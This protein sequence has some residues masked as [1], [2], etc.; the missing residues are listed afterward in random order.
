[1]A[2]IRDVANYAKVSVGTVSN[3]LNNSPLVKDA[4]R[5]RVL[6]AIEA[7]DFHPMAAARTLTTQRTNTL[8]MVRTE[9]R[10][11]NSRIES[12][13]VILDL[14][15]GITSAAVESGI[16]LTFWT[17]YVGQSEMELYR[18][19]VSGR[20]VDGF[21]LFALREEDPRIQY[22]QEQNFP[23]VTFGRPEPLETSYWIDVDSAYGIETSVRH[24]F[25]LG[26]TRI[27]YIAPPHEQFLARQRWEGFT[28]GMRA[29]GLVINS[30]FIY[31]GD[32]SERSGQ[33]G[34]HYFLDLPEPPTAIICSNDRMALG[35][36]H[37]AQSRHLKV[38][39]DISI[40][41]YD[42]IPL[43]RYSYPSLTTL[44]QPTSQIGGMLF[45]LLTSI[46]EEQPDT[47]LT[48][49]LIKP[50]LHVRQSTGIHA[51][52]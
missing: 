17:T 10:P 43:S 31:E 34:T 7:L 15:E 12:D 27:A 52:K 46:I 26:H 28:S 4:T 25:D 35:A 19:L 49:H 22:L 39:K 1:M 41:G 5:R 50:E 20:Q 21:I 51:K 38:G 2:T 9:L 40:V 3:V 13:P 42:N 36:I 23:F 6:A 45:R 8:G 32:F 44:S 33:L 47:S 18:R 30:D 37:A 29:A 16:G 24:V 11:H 14:I 48:G